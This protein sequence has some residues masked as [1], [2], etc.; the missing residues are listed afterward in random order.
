MPNRVLRIG[1]RM[2]AAASRASSLRASYDGRPL[3]LTTPGAV[4]WITGGLSD[5]IDLAASSDPV[6]VVVTNEGRA[7]IT[8]EIEG[9]RILS[10]FQIDASEWEVLTVP[11]FDSGAGLA[12][13]CTFGG[14]QLSDFI[15]DRE[16]VGLNITPVIVGARMIL[17]EP[18][19]V[20]LRSLGADAAR[21][22]IAGIG[23]WRPGVTTD[24]DVAARVNYELEKRGAKALC[25]I[26][27]GDERLR[28][29][30][31]PLAI[32][33]V[34]RDALMAVVVARRGGLHVAATRIAVRRADDPIVDLVKKL[35]HVNDQVLRTS[36]P[37]N[38]WGAATTTLA[39]GYER[40]GYSGAWR[41]HFQGGPIAFEQREFEL[42]P[43]Q[44]DSPYWGVASAAGAAVAW[45][46]SLKGGAKI[47]DTYLVGVS[48]LQLVTT[49]EGWPV[50]S[51]PGGPLR[52]QVKVIE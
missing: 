34:V 19:Q 9:P 11:W 2:N 41:E 22:L 51:S 4:N 18:E 5:P 40:I 26:V 15:S 24:F 21:A 27:G 30:R 25:L 50:T 17:S 20:D 37:G 7:L 12:A 49:S 1:A 10:D 31:H 14:C 16:D 35:V 33:E 6:W 13:A 36:L 3:L 44:Y 39:D 38:T 48:D 46:P 29:F 28:S 52:S 47:E 32:G 23:D 8:N 45:N 42:A 43:G